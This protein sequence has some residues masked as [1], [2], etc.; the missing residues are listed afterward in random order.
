MGLF[1]S[2]GVDAAREIHAMADDAMAKADK[3]LD[4]VGMVAHGVR[5]DLTAMADNIID[6]FECEIHFKIKPARAEAP[7]P[8][9]VE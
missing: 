4:K 1:D 3:L 8:K 7:N 2:V 9:P 5:A 6:R